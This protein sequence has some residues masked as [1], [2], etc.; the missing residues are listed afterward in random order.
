MNPNVLRD[1]NRVTFVEVGGG[2]KVVAQ[3]RRAQHDGQIPDPG[4][5]LLEILP[6]GG[7]IVE[8]QWNQI[9]NRKW[10]QAKENRRENQQDEDQA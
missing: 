10:N 6:D 5:R 8:N 9:V 3:G 7:G 2:S 1:S 4:W